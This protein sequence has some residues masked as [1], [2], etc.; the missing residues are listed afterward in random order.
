LPWQMKCWT[1]VM[2]HGRPC[3]THLYNGGFYG[4]FQSYRIYRL[5]PGPLDRGW[6]S[7]TY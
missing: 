3:E 6:D 4:L 5:W 7:T 2:L 1:L